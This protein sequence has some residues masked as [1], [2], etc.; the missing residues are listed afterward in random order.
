MIAS[1]R[2]AAFEFRADEARG[3]LVRWLSDRWFAPSDLTNKMDILEVN[4]IY[5]PFWVCSTSVTTQYFGKWLETIEITKDDGTKVLQGVWTPGERTREDNYSN[6]LLFGS[7]EDQYVSWKKEFSEKDWDFSTAS[8]VPS[9]QSE[10]LEPVDWHAVWSLHAELLKKEEKEKAKKEWES[11]GTKVKDIVVQCTFHHTT[12]QLIFLP[13]YHLSYI[14]EGKTY[15]AK[16]H[17]KTKN[18]VGDRPYGL[19]VGGGLLNKFGSKF[20]G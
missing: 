3:L 12:Y 13:V 4:P 15:L 5:Y 11:D 19:G 9:V 2:V 16:A 1:S 7:T 6:I 10:F 17:G 20:F 14:F 18:V 8:L